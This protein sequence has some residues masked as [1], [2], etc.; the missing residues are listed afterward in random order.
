MRSPKWGVLQLQI[1]RHDHQG[2]KV[3]DA[4]AFNQ[5]PK[6]FLILSFHLIFGSS[7]YLS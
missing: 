4:A 1:A 7:L 6:T 2:F 5:F 3:A